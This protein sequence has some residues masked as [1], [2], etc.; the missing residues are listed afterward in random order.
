MCQYG[1]IFE[2]PNYFTQNL[3]R[4]AK[5]QGLVE[6]YDSDQFMIGRN[7]S[8][9]SFLN[10]YGFPKVNLVI[11]PYTQYPISADPLGFSGNW[12]GFHFVF[13]NLRGMDMSAADKIFNW[14]ELIGE[15]K[16]WGRK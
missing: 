9:A 11:D 1:P 15:L 12:K 4:E 16:C 6:I 13:Q 7:Y 5:Y 2:F 3:I 10:F 14:N 8:G